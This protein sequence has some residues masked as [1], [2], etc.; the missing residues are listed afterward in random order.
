[1]C[2]HVPSASV[3]MPPLFIALRVVF[4]GAIFA[5]L[6]CSRPSSW[7]ALSS[8]EAGIEP[9]RWTDARPILEAFAI[10]DARAPAPSLRASGRRLSWPAAPCRRPRLAMS[11]ADQ[12][13]IP[14]GSL[15]HWSPLV[16]VRAG[17]KFA[18]LRRLANFQHIAPTRI[19]I[20]TTPPGLPFQWVQ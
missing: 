19:A 13:A 11:P 12:C 3:A 14:Q 17:G 16:L 1:M 9:T 15:G 10:S 5:F 4:F 7:P 2:Q 8:V 6:N 18:A 20:G